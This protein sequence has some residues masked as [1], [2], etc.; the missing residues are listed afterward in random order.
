ML[1]KLSKPAFLNSFTRSLIVVSPNRFY[2]NNREIELVQDL[3]GIDLREFE[4]ERS[5][6]DTKPTSSQILKWDDIMNYSNPSQLAQ[7]NMFD[8]GEFGNFREISYEDLQCF[9]PT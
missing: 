1:S 6:I 7:E 4:N 8:N 2:S 3:T 9:T 5:I